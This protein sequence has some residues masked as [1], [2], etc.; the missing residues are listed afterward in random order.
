MR[1][2]QRVNGVYF[3]VDGRHRDHGHLLLLHKANQNLVV[4]FNL[5]LDVCHVVLYFL[6]F[7]YFA[8][9]VAHVLLDAVDLIEND[10]E[11]LA[12][13][14]QLG[15]HSFGLGARQLLQGELIDLLHVSGDL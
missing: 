9:E 3:L 10:L 15:L 5:A 11:N 2:L 13:F 14:G 12:V 6:R 7:L 4:N 8:L 1:L